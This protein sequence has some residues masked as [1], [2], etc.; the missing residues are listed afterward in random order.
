MSPDT[1]A[2][3]SGDGF[4]GLGHTRHQQ[5]KEVLQHGVDHALI[6][7]VCRKI[8]ARWHSVVSQRNGLGGIYTTAKEERLNDTKSIQVS[9]K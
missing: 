5:L 4:C 2:A 9:G 1:G 8:K 6:P 3:H 7:D